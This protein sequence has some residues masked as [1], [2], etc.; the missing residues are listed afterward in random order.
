[1]DL[2]RT[3]AETR[4]ITSEARRRRRSVGFVPTM[5]ALHAG[6]ASLLHAAR[7]RDQLVVV[8]IFVNP[9]QFGPHE[10]FNK[11]PR[12][13]EADFALC[14]QAGVDLIF[15]PPVE[16]MYPE[17]SCTTVHVARLTERLEGEFRPG[18]FDGVTT[19]VCK[20]LGIVQPDRAYFG[21]KDYQQLIVVR[22]MVA[23]LNLPVEIVGCPTV[24]NADGLAL[25]SRN[26]YL[27]E[28]ERAAAP[29]LHR[30][31]QIGA[32]VLRA[33]GRGDAAAARATR[34]LASEPRFRVQYLETVDPDTLAPHPQAGLPAV[35]VAAAYL[36]ET[37]LI[38]NVLV[39]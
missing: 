20:L 19:V 26:R 13:L 31:L 2:V 8:S 32:E 21:Q 15:A 10:D 29:A 38:D 16:E 25:S 6:H 1:M 37:R 27:S 24:R 36:G 17:E 18:H 12:T 11:Y 34:A 28:E 30:A 9:T 22:R 4:K 14:E 7:A 23:D 5:G 39:E 35:L 33:G 3:I